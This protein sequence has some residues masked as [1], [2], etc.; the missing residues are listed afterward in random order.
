MTLKMAELDPADYLTDG[1]TV[2][3]CLTG[4]LENEDARGVVDALGMSFG[5]VAA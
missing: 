1:E 3:V 4:A 5:L 2:A